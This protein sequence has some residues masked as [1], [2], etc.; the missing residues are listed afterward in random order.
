M[1]TE[2]LPEPAPRFR[3]SLDNMDGD[4]V[5]VFADEHGGTT[6]ELWMIGRQEY[7]EPEP[8]G[9]RPKPVA[10]PFHF[11]SIEQARAAARLLVVACDTL[12]S[13]GEQLVAAATPVDRAAC[14]HH[15]HPHS[16]QRFARALP[17]ELV[18][19]GCGL[20]LGNADDLVG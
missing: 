3:F 12:N 20:R 18:C 16:R 6:A 11:N 10:I 8:R 4:P 14:E 2:V 19:D 9:P 5:M 17:H 1:D 7:D 13:V 15:Q